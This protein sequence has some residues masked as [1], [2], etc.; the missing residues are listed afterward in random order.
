MW[1]ARIVVVHRTFHWVTIHR[2][3]AGDSSDVAHAE[4]AKRLSAEFEGVEAAILRL[5]SANG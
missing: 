3:L 5:T 2:L 4:H 1:T